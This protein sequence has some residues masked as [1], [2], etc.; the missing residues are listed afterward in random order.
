[1]FNLEQYLEYEI[2]FVK[3]FII[4]DFQERALFELTSAKKRLHFFSRLCHGYNQYFNEQ[5]MSAFDINTVDIE[6]MVSDILLK[7]NIL[8][9]TMAYDESFDKQYVSLNEGISY[10]Y[11]TKMPLI[12]LIEK[13]VAIF[14]AEAMF[15]K[16]PRF[17]L[18]RR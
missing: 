7:K 3:N 16:P 6:K 9:F 18:C 1:M 8:C 13:S 15:E 12:L 2:F 4:K 5:Y 11:Q 17:L 14:Q 10:L